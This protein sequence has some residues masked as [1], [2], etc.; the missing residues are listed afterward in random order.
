MS[1]QKPIF[2]MQSYNWQRPESRIH[3]HWQVNEKKQIA[4]WKKWPKDMNKLQMK[5]AQRA[6]EHLTRRLPLSNQRN[7]QTKKYATCVLGFSS[8]I[9]WIGFTCI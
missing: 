8:E 6:N 2:A 9:K 7:K 5:A 3:E 1:S 4:Q